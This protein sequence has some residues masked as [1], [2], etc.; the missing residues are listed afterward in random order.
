MHL[1]K[2]SDCR[3]R[4]GLNLDDKPRHE[5]CCA[6]LCLCSLDITDW[7]RPRG[8]YRVAVPV[9]EEYLLVHL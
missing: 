1:G 4:K 8:H 7:Q 9:G 5:E 2:L 3:P 6:V